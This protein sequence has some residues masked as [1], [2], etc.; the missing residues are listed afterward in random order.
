[1]TGND[2]FREIG[3]IDE[4][5]IKEA[6][7][8]TPPVL[9]TE[10]RQSKY[11]SRNTVNVGDDYDDYVDL[12]KNITF[13]DVEDYHKIFSEKASNSLV[14]VVNKDFYKQNEKEIL[15]SITENF[16]ITNIKYE[17]GR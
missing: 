2:L 4:K 11:V 7:F 9:Y 3:N 5:Y 10:S 8:L 15:K 6:L 17:Q 1:M 14:I 13:K 16:E 12:I